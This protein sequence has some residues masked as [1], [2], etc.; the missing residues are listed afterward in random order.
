MVVSGVAAWFVGVPLADR[1]VKVLPPG[2]LFWH[3][4]TAVAAMQML[5]GL[6]VI[7]GLSAIVTSFIPEGVLAGVTEGPRWPIAAVVFGC[8]LLVLATPVGS[9]LSK[10]L[11][12][13]STWWGPLIRGWAT[14]VGLT[15]LVVGALQ[16]ARA[17]VG[18]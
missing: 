10:H 16:I 13:D 8:A 17:A 1:L 12:S 5:G 18:G 15:V 7:G 14:L 11:R 6:L 3:N 2:W 9:W 4:H